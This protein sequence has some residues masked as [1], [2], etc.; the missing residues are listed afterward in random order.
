MSVAQAKP[1]FQ[2]ALADFLASIALI[3]STIINFLSYET[4]HKSG[5]VCNDGL[6]LSLDR[7][8]MFNILYVFV[9][10][11][12]LIGYIIYIR[13]IT[14]TQVPYIPSSPGSNDIRNYDSGS[15]NAKF[16]NSCILF[17]HLHI[18]N[19]SCPAVDLRHR[20]ITR[21]FTFASVLGVLICCTGMG[22][23]GRAQLS[24]QEFA[25]RAQ[26]VSLLHAESPDPP[27]SSSTLP[28]T[29]KQVRRMGAKLS[30][31]K[32]EGAAIEGAVVEAP[33]QDQPAT[34]EALSVPQSS[35]QNL[36]G[37]EATLEAKPK[38]VV[39]PIAADSKPIPGA[40]DVIT[41]TAEETVSAISQQIAGPVEEVLNKSIGAVEAMMAAVGLKDEVPDP[42]PKPETLVDLSEE[43]KPKMIFST[44]KAPEGLAYLPSDLP[45]SQTISEAL[46]T[47]P[48]AAAIADDVA[49][50]A[51]ER[52]EIPSQFDIRARPE[53]KELLACMNQDAEPPAEPLNYE[54]SVDPS[55]LNFDPLV[56]LGDMGQGVSTAVNT[57][58]DLI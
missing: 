44:P 33:S 25:S 19:D 34:P 13:T 9:W 35:E 51:V 50:L 36:S 49:P 22:G 24:V 31:R 20:N 8:W 12:P 54:V 4:A 58:N 57:I 55:T 15:T 21:G 29:V 37:A 46:L 41:Q 2:L 23:S 45:S 32:S 48:V 11:I 17:L 5:V 1:L 7:R 3:G 18:E 6:S 40:L 56:D 26:S 14:L 39:P 52:E 43:T 47:E 28:F 42:E 30:R 38:E 10:F 16:C 53:R 27:H